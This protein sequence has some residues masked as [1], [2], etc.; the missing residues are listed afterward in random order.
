MFSNFFFVFLFFLVIVLFTDYKRLNGVLYAEFPP[1]YN[2]YLYFLTQTESYKRWQKLL[3]FDI[4]G[5]RV[6]AVLL[7]RPGFMKFLFPIPMS[8]VIIV[9]K[10]YALWADAFYM[11]IVRPCVRLHVCLFVCLFIRLLTFEVPF[12]C[13]FV[14]T[15]QSRMSK[16]FCDLESSRK[17]IGKKWSD[18]KKNLLLIKD[19]K[20][21]GIF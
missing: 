18:I 11:Q 20:S 10:A 14:P 8:K 19:V 1:A 4:G 9:F 12:E 13:L 17:N 3:S 21:P 5:R 15:S 7:I 2:Y 16:I 6:F